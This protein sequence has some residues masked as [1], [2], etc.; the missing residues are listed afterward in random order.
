MKKLFL[1][2]L[3]FIT[4]QCL[5]GQHIEW[6]NKVLEFS[7]QFGVRQYSANQILGRPNVLPSLGA[8]PNAWSP[9]KSGRAE[10]IKVSFA[11][12]MEIQQ[13]AI[14]ETSNPGGIKQ[15]S[16]FD[17]QGQEHVLYTFEPHYLPIEGR[18]FRLFFDKTSYDVA[19]VKVA[20]DGSVLHSHFGIDAIAI[21][22]SRDPITVEINVTDKINNDYVTIPLGPTVNTP[23]RELRPLISPN[24]KTLYFSRRNYPGNIGGVKDDEDIWFSE[25]DSTNG[26]WQEAKNMGRPLNNKG[27]ISSVPSLQMGKICCYSLVMHIIAKTV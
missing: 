19:V 24:A 3:L 15:I 1:T 13:I 17:T 7:S 4:G 16:V 25:R 10:S 18:L 26:E 9:K 20:I 11:Q 14:A 5:F 12:P 22:D 2:V 21:S 27:L 23:F 8:S 6:A